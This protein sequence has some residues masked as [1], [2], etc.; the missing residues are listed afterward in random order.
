[1]K[2]F[3]TLKSFLLKHKWSYILGVAWLLLIDGV[4]LIVPLI[5]KSLTDNLQNGT[6]DFKGI[7]RYALLI[8][9]T[10]LIIAAGRYFWR[11]YI[12]GTSRILEYYLRKKLF[13][14]LL[15]L[16]PNY[17]NTHKTGD[18]MAHATNDINA[19]RTAVGPGTVMIVDAVFMI[20]LSL[21][22]MIRTT[23]LKFTFISVFTMPIIMILVTRF[24]RIIYNRFKI[25]QEAFSDLTDVTQE[26]F[27]GIR[28]IKSFVQE[29]L[30]SSNFEKT[31]RDNLEKNLSL[32]KVHGIFNPLLHF[33][34]SLSYLVLIYYG[35]RQVIAGTISL[36]DFVAFNSYLGLLMW[37]TRAFG[38]VINVL[39]RG[40]ASLDRLNTI[41]SEES[42]IKEIQEPVKLKS[43][44]G[45]IKFDNVSFKYPNSNFYALRNISF[46]LKKGDILA[47][48]GRTGSGKST[49]VNLLLRLYDIESGIISVDGVNIKQLDLKSYREKVGFVPQ[50][51]FLFSQ[52]IEDNIGFAFDENVPMEDVVKAARLAEVYDNIMDFPHKFATI[53][54][55]R[56]V[57]LSGG[58]KQRTSIARALIKDPSIVI[59]DDSLSAVDTE[60]EEKILNNLNK[61]T[62]DIT[63]IVISHR[64]STVKDST[65]IIYLNEGTITERG[66]H[67]DLLALDGEYKDLYEKQLLEEKLS[68]G[69][70]G[71]YE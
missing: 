58:Q 53:L 14:H 65:E 12:Q 42:D 48:V 18:L 34:A 26:S 7:I 55:E 57:T 31:N 44:E 21:I 67:K 11:I 8:F 13:N 6:L 9:L 68:S 62:N 61:A 66:S 35:G 5:F 23:S 2:S 52:S 51:N 59:L 69:K 3:L 19:V 39:Q 15:T 37:P 24:G 64:I 56:G 4:Q 27:S 60:T 29:N 22:M 63:T 47:I 16:S 40:A 32:V 54:G 70:E 38:M 1:M 49:I 28:V 10:G 50:E 25:V 71:Y 46:D 33:I 45:N 30:V 43:I 20:I 17:F 41:F 36:G